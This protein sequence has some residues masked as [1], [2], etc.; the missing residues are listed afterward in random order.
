MEEQLNPINT[1]SLR[2]DKRTIV[3]AR[4]ANR[5]S[6]NKLL[7]KR[8]GISVV[9]AVLVVATPVIYGTLAAPSYIITDP[10]DHFL[11]SLGNALPLFFAFFSALLY[12]PVILQETQSLGW[13]PIM[14]RQGRVRYTLSHIARSAAFGACTFGASI[15]CAAFWAFIVVPRAGW[16]T[17]HPDERIQPF[18]QQ[19]TFSQFAQPSMWVFVLFLTLW[20]AF[21]G[22]L[23][24]VLFSSL[25]LHL[26]NPFL[27][28][29]TGPAVLFLIGT[30]LAI[31]RLEVFMPDNAALPT[32]LIQ[33]PIIQPVI[34][35]GIM[36]FLVAAIA[37]YTTWS[38]RTPRALQ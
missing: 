29:I 30:A 27:A 17:Y 20:V 33:G 35:T 26:R 38:S 34:T 31:A 10:A 21:Y 3:G 37:A 23:Y 19:M 8:Y 7:I 5:Q 13:L 32:G 4:P 22:A 11:F 18:T 28:I 14:A 36:V 25:A 16:I 24:S 12:V 9:V 6:A 1:A 15:A 2:L